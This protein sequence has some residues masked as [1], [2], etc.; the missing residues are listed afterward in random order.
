MKT[1][2]LLRLASLGALGFAAATAY[3]QVFVSGDATSTASSANWAFGHRFTVGG[4]TLVVTHLGVFVGGGELGSSTQ[5]RIWDNGG[6]VVGG[7]DFGPGPAPVGSFVAD[8]YRYFKLDLPIT[9]S[10]GQTY[11]LSYWS[12]GTEQI[13]DTTNGT[14][15]PTFNPI[16]LTYVGD[17]FASVIGDK[18]PDTSVGSSIYKGPNLIVPEPET[19]AFIAGLGLVGYG[20]YRRRQDFRG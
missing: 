17:Y 18:F 20:L 1:H 13:G 5:V 12:P 4:T 9:L 11:T 6:S 3:G 8:N 15:A 14:T 7:R 16:G 19:Y 2:S 10:A